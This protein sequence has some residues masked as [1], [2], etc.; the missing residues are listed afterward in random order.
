MEEEVDD[1]D[2]DEEAVVFDDEDDMGMQGNR[3]ERQER[4]GYAHG[5]RQD[6]LVAE[7]M[8]RLERARG[9]LERYGGRR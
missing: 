1:Y 3:G 6:F 9:L 5:G 2:Y 4:M 7:K 8:G